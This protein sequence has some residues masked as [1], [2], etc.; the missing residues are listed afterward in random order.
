MLVVVVL[1]FGWWWLGAGGG[2]GQVVALGRC[3]FGF[4]FG[5]WPLWQLL[6][7]SLGCVAIKGDW[8]GIVPGARCMERDL[9]EIF[10]CNFL[11][12]QYIYIYI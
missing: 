10:W 6:D 9:E 4:G 5:C 8:L 3:W 11:K 12:V 7:V 1:V 2:F